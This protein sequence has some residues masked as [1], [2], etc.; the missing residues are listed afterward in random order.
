MLND[1][2]SEGRG[3]KFFHF[4]KDDGKLLMLSGKMK[5]KFEKKP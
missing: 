5:V 4:M 3:P 2:Y 1:V